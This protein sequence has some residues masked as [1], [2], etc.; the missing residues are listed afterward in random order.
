M[1]IFGLRRTNEKKKKKL[2]EKKKVSPG[3]TTRPQATTGSGW[4]NLHD[5]PKPHRR[6]L[7]KLY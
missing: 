7:V 2:E 5:A 4:S 3:G 1:S 6:C